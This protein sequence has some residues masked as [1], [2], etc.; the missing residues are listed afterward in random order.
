MPV[1]SRVACFACQFPRQTKYPKE[2]RH[3]DPSLS[4][5]Y[6]MSHNRRSTRTNKTNP[7]GPS[8]SSV[9][10]SGTAP[11]KILAPELSCAFRASHPLSPQRKSNR[12]NTPSA[13]LAIGP[14]KEAAKTCRRHLGRLTNLFMFSAVLCGLDGT[15]GRSRG[16]REPGTK[17]LAAQFDALLL[18]VVVNR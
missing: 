7:P 15:L 2:D 4:M 13:F 14:P 3:V 11:P 6:S 17:Y 5:S 9:N 8:N 12:V 18:R 10:E 16:L 1:S